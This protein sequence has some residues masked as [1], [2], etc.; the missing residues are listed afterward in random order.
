MRKL[1]RNAGRPDGELFDEPWLDLP[2]DTPSPPA[3]AVHPGR[4]LTAPPT[5]PDDS[6]FY[7]QWFHTTLGI[8]SM[9]VWT[10]YTGA[11][12]TVAVF[13]D[14][15]EWA[16]ADLS[17]RVN[18]SLSI[19]SETGDPGGQ[20]L[21]ADDNHGTA[22][23]GVIAASRNGSGMVGVAYDATLLSIYL[24]F[25]SGTG[26][27]EFNAFLHAADHADVMNNSWGY[28]QPFSDDFGDFAFFTQVLAVTYA[29]DSGRGGLGTV[30]VQAAGN[31]A[32]DGGNANYH[33]YTNSRFSIAVGA[34]INLDAQA[35]NYSS[36]GAS[37]LVSAPIYSSDTLR[38]IA[39]TD[40][41]AQA[42]YSPN[43]DYFDGFNGTSAAAPEVSGTVALMLDAN[44]ALGYRDV[45]EILVYSSRHGMA[46]GVEIN[47]ATNW[48]GGGLHFSEAAGAGVIDA[49]AAVRLAETWTTQHILANEQSISLASP[50]PLAI[51]D[52]LTVSSTIVNTTAI[53]IDWVEVDV[54]ISHG[55]RGEL[56]L[57]LISP[58]GLVSVLMDQPRILIPGGSIRDTTD[59]LQWTFGSVQQWGETGVG[60]WT[61]EVYD[62]ITG[63][64]GQLN[65]WNLRL[66]G[67]APTT[68]D[69]YVYT[70]EFAE[71]FTRDAAHAAQRATL[72]DSDGGIDTINAAA[73][74]GRA[75]LRLDGQASTID[76]HTLLIAADEIEI[77]YAG[78]G[79]DTLFGNGADNRLYG[80]RGDD[81]LVL[82]AGSDT[83]YGGAGIDILSFVQA[84]TRV[85]ADLATGQFVGASEFG[86]DIFAGFEG[87]QGGSS[88]DWLAGTEL[89]D[90]LLGE[91][92]TRWKA[93]AATIAMT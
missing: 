78:D 1:A 47:G 59:D 76:G 31:E 22:V 38:N 70:D 3:Q 14:G 55:S 84:T 37:V 53:D 26:Q 39:T 56:T 91:E 13:D 42:G 36:P 41:V 75:M 80:G 64:T 33:G 87:L 58:S 68:D 88:D 72:S 89:Q 66:Y 60:T 9:A 20:P 46:N 65:G 2:G 85:E 10:D 21:T 11:G 79:D 5:P 16:H 69:T 43:S 62:N 74:S 12:I 19:H 35:A 51:P 49:R 86:A 77:A 81:T 54:D 27:G 73:L 90:V 25:Q 18:Q 32:L 63:T 82:D 7:L 28:F 67:D 57:R 50:T 93:A 48:N 52:Q 71:M 23:A 61:L 83:L 40:R 15:I 45:Q 24:D 8:N 17:A 29:A 6:E 92:T 30:L 34:T 44:A 4:L